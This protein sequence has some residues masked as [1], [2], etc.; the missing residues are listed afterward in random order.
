M[1]CRRI[2][3]GCL[4]NLFPGAEWRPGDTSRPSPEQRRSRKS[5][6]LARSAIRKIY[7]RGNAEMGTKT[8]N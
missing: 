6:R 3:L 1:K 5:G 7:G 2:H 4:L 8:G